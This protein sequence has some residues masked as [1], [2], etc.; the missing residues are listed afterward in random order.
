MKKDIKTINKKDA[1][2]IDHKL[3]TYKVGRYKQYGCA[4]RDL[5]VYRYVKTTRKNGKTTTEIKEGFCWPIDIREFRK[6]RKWPNRWTA[7]DQIRAY[8]RT[9][10]KMLKH[11][12]RVFTK[13]KGPIKRRAKIHSWW[14]ITSQWDYRPGSGPR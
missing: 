5:F 12:F 9:T 14:F 2:T 1:I 7:A 11:P 10:G 6:D 3:Q 8:S 4:E 13:G